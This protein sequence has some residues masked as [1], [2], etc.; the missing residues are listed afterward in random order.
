MGNLKFL[1]SLSL[2]CSATTLLHAEDFYRWVDE[3][4]S[5]HYTTTPPVQQSTKKQKVHDYLSKHDKILVE[6]EH[7]LNGG[8]FD[9]TQLSAPPPIQNPLPVLQSSVVERPL[10][11][12]EAHTAMPTQLATTPNTPTIQTTTSTKTTDASKAVTQHT[13][14]VESSTTLAAPSLAPIIVPA[15]NSTPTKALAISN[16]SKSTVLAYCDNK[17]CWGTDGIH[18]KRTADDNFKD[19]NGRECRAIDQKMRCF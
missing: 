19:P 6:D 8:R 16:P 7:Q 10:A 4:G 15:E 17:G 1:L 9:D 3:N 18:Y 5:T 2:I 11:T 12:Q 13:T 14:L